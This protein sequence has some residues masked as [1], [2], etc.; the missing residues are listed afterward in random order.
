MV[1]GRPVVKSW[2][3]PTELF[4]PPPPPPYTAP[5]CLYCPLP[6][7]ALLL[8]IYTDRPS[9][10]P[11]NMDVQWVVLRRRTSSLRPSVLCGGLTMPTSTISL[12][13]SLQHRSMLCNLDGGISQCTDMSGKMVQ[14]KC[15]ANANA[16]QCSEALFKVN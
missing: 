6:C 16:I 8:Y 14:Y 7:T 15:K 12:C 5:L 9:T 4:P 2:A 13:S 10:D 11:P 3:R 1:M